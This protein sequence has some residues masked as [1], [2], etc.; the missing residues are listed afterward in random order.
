M[1]ERSNLVSLLGGPRS[2]PLRDASRLTREIVDELFLPL[3]QGRALS[4]DAVGEIVTRWRDAREA[5][6]A[7]LQKRLGT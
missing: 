5:F 3:Q 1:H 6:I 4:D 7:E 2:S